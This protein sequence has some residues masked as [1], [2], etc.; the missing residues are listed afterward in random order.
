VFARPVAIETGKIAVI[1]AQPGIPDRRGE[2]DAIACQGPACAWF[3]VQADEKGNVVG[4]RCA[5]AMG[6]VAAGMLHSAITDAT[7]KLIP[8]PNQKK[9]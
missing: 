1:G 2:P 8:D 7:S 9:S 3:I 6:V 5:A 4:G